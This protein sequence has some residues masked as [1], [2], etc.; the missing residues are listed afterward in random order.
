[1]NLPTHILV[2]RLSALGDV[3]MT[4]PV[5]KIAAENYPEIRFTVLTR[6]QFFPLFD[7][8]KNVNVH[9][10]DVYGKH[11]GFGLLK[12]ASEIKSLGIDAAAD[13]HD[14]IRSKVIRSALRTSGIRIEIIDKGRTERKAL[15]RPV[16]K[17][18]KPL[19]STHERYAEVFRNLG[20]D[21]RLDEKGFL[22]TREVTPRLLQ[23]IGQ[24]T[25]KAIG[26]APFAAFKSKMYSLE[27][28]Q[29]VLSKLDSEGRYQIFLFGGG[30]EEERMLSEW[31]HQY[32]NVRNVAG[33]LTFP[34]ELSLI[35]NLDL[36]VSMDS[37]N[38]HLAAMFDVP[39]L[40]LW[41][42]T[43][44][45]AGFQPFMQPLSNCLMPDQ[46]RFPEIPTSIYGN[47]YPSK[48]ENV[49]DE[50]PVN[51]IHGKIEQILN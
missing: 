9:E 38:G 36:M 29:E 28:I 39:V 3:A 32:K 21:I 17:T 35:S 1:M 30:A 15:T 34:E 12:L 45:Y 48:L 19:R 31:E 51:E 22:P 27:K 8:I 24:H 43:H 14:V 7:D 33:Q 18:F 37:G 16:N 25:R 11:K 46:D 23:F 10:A 47:K 44:P 6:K 49:M 13:L 26:V 41:G 50:I 2:I 20:M 42:V 5:L 4:V 40:T